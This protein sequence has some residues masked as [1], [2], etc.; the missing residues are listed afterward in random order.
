MERNFSLKNLI[1]T[2]G[3]SDFSL[4]IQMILDRFPILI[5]GQNEELVDELVN[6]MVTLAP[7]RSEMV[8]YSDFV[9]DQEFLSLL[10]DEHDDFNSPRIIIRA[11]SNTSLHAVEHISTFKGWILG[12]TNKNGM[13]EKLIDDFL[14]KEKRFT[15]IFL[16]QL[17]EITLKI[18]GMKP[19]DLDLS[20]EKK[21]LDKAIK[22]TE[23]ALEKMKRVLNKKVKLKKESEILKAVMNFNIEE[24]EIQ[25]N[26]LQ[27][28]IQS[29]VHASSRALAVLSRID[30]LHELGMD[31]KIADQTLLQTI[32]Y[33][34]IRI[35]RLLEFI[36]SE[37]GVD[38]FSCIKGT[39]KDRSGDKIDGL[40]G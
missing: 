19:N 37:F 12:F 34:Q 8:Y 33:E 22:Q 17:D 2:L 40:W 13:K 39:W 36:K 7:H 16:D 21:M 35:E 5:V 18:Y 28:E 38:F 31:I 4:L 10:Q 25:K 29:F 24:E 32:D 1:Q 3:H 26:I 9:E 23:I 6:K 14:R 30:L 15:I 27:Q 20:F 11:P